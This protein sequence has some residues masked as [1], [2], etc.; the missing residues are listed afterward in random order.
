MGAAPVT[1]STQIKCCNIAHGV[2]LLD[3][4]RARLNDRYLHGS[5]YTI[6]SITSDGLT[7]ITITIVWT[8]DFGTRLMRDDRVY[9]K[10]LV[11]GILLWSGVEVV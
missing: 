9:V 4:I 2:Y 6:E 10:G 1:D 8:R 3:D 5:P 7:W 11:A